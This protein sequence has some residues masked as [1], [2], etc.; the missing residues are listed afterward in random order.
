MNVEEF[1]EFCLSLPE[2]TENM[3]FTQFR[4]ANSTLVF[5]IHGKTFCYVDIDKF[6]SCMIKGYPDKIISLKE[7]YACVH[8]PSHFGAKHWMTIL[9]NEDMDDA[10]LKNL[11][12]DSYEIVV[13]S[14]PKKKRES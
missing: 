14:L 11:I 8:N 4:G 10:T 13:S 5:Y 6:D 7:R 12:N 9:I 3:P 2:V 1:R